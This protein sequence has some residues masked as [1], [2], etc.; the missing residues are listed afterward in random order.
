MSAYSRRIF[1]HLAYLDDSTLKRKKPK[2]QVMSGII[3]ED[4]KFKLTEMG[5]SIVP[6]MLMPAE[7]MEQF[8]EFH[9]C[10]LYG[11]H[12]VFEGIEQDIRFSAIERLLGMIELLELPIVYG[13]VD[14]VRLS[15]EI[16]ASANPPDIC[17][18]ACLDGINS[19]AEQDTAKQIHAKLGNHIENYSTENMTPHVL[20]G[21]LNRLVILVVDECDK[22][23]RET[24][25]KSYRSLRPPR[26]VTTI[27]NFHDDMYFGDSRYSI[28]IQ[29][30]DL[31]SYFI[32]R[33]LE[34]D[35]E[36]EHF[37]ELIHPHV[38]SS[39]V[40]P[41]LPAKQ[42]EGDDGLA[43]TIVASEALTDGE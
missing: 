1:V 40:H 25:H 38:C 42:V 34:G 12:G 41:L 30:A 2:W 16:Y 13:A 33:H 18:R 4:K 28:G 26:N 5:V 14:L 10:E 19:W 20:D 9:A 7:R 35:Q 37:Y 29:L 27:S 3:I 39:Q 22:N 23:I 8:E 15:T 31:C 24:L 32:A 43:G 36:T 11:G 6:E 17:F 21:L